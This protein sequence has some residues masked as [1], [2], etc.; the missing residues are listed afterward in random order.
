ML[1]IVSSFA[2][3]IKRCL[4]LS[5]LLVHAHAAVWADEAPADSLSTTLEEVSVTALKRL[6][7][8]MQE[9]EAVTILT[10]AEL[11]RLGARTIRGVSDV[12]PNFYMPEYGSRIT[13]TIY[14]RGIGAR[15]DNPSVGLNVDNVPYLNK[16]AYDFDVA[17]IA[18]VEML[19]G[20]QS[21]LYGR[22][23]MAGVINITTL[24]PMRYQGWKVF[25]EFASGTSIKG[26]VG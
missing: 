7:P 16:D 13:S 10:E 19:R 9:P 4:I 26:S 25:G 18:M 1:T 23:T 2:A 20:P 3:M 17:D 8:V 6:N 24:S 5:S 14:V 11:E 12:V 15:M 22:N 21:T